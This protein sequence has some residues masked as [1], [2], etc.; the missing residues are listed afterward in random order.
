MHH[1]TSQSFGFTSHL[2]RYKPIIRIYKPLAPLYKP[3]IR[4]YKPLAQIYKP[5]IRIY[6]PL[7]PLYKPNKAKSSRTS[8]CFLLC[9]FNVL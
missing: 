6:K 5:I 4:I 8:D 3:I 2:P 1:Y 7:A 9:L